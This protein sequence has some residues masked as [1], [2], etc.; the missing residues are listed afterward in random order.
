VAAAA[1]AG[2][3]TTVTGT[4]GGLLFAAWAG[5]DRLWMAGR[6][7]ASRRARARRSRRRTTGDTPEP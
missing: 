3:L 2:V 6:R 7:V 4:V 1:A 5:G